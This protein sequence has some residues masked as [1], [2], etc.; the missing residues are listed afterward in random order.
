MTT[1]PLMFWR[2]MRLMV[3]ACA[4]VVSAGSTRAAVALQA[5]ERGVVGDGTTL[6]TAAIQKLIDETSA[7]GGGTVTFPAGRYLTGTIQLKD[8]VTLH[9]DAGAVLLGSTR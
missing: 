7:Q 1:R 4:W 2:V 9:L 3:A 8:G 6:N 5:A